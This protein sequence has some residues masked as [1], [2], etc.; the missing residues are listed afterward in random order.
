MRGGTL[1]VLIGMFLFIGSATAQYSYDDPYLPKLTSTSS[2]NS[3]L[4]LSDTPASYAGQG[5]SC[6]K[7][8]AGE[9]AIEFG[10]CGGGGG[11]GD[12]WIDGG[13]YIYPNSTFANNINIFGYIRANDWTNVSILESNILDL[14]H[15]VDTT[16]GNCSG[17][18]SCDNILY[19]S[20]LPLANET[21]SYCGNITGSNFNLCINPD[22][23]IPDTNFT[24]ECGDGEYGDGSGSCINFNDTVASLFSESQVVYNATSIVTETGT[25]DS[26]NI[27][28][29][30]AY[31]EGDTY[32]VS[33]VSNTPGFLINITFTNVTSF[34]T[35]ALRGKYDG[36][37]GHTVDLELFRLSTQTWD[38]FG[39]ITDQPDF[40]VTSFPVFI[41]S[42]F[43]NTTIGGGTVLFRINHDDPGNP[44]HDYSLDAVFLGQ[45]T[46][47][48]TGGGHDDTTGRDDCAMN[49][50]KAMCADGEIRNFTGNVYGDPGINATFYEIFARV[51]WSWIQNAPAF[52]LIT[53]VQAWI[54]GNETETKAELRIDIDSNWTDLETRKFNVTGGEVTGVVNFTEN[55]T[56]SAGGHELEISGNGSCTFIGAPSGSGID[57]CI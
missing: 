22:T 52:A 29:I 55:I 25:L 18:Q 20:D 9:N 2:L 27:T 49:H 32:N 16:I 3:F 53:D 26:G 17:D 24:T 28:S 19:N 11:A 10:V 47:L 15:T 33:E 14:S 23:T 48:I 8:N 54:L 7:V 1:I 4:S 44:A 41:G 36:G 6:L 31:G 40:G 39:D 42:D 43:I 34:N 57:I 45:V 38:D 13:T 56:I 12:K 50:P 30:Q 37:A 35:V 21:L 51:N 46:G 5:T